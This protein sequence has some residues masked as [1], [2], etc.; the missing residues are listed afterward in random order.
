MPRELIT[1]Q[2]G[3]A[4]NQLGCRFWDMA[5]SEHAAYSTNNVYDESM[6]SFFRH[7]SSRGED[8]L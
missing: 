1:I 4:G 3:Q 5:L 7:V 6:S 2:I 8:A